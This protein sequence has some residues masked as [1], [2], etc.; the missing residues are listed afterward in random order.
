MIYNEK[1]IEKLISV[2]NELLEIATRYETDVTWSHYD[3]KDEFI[4][5]LDRHL[6]KLQSQD[7]SEIGELKSLFAPTGSLQEI[8]LSSGWA[9]NYLKIASDFDRIASRIM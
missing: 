2:L 7:L 6:S 5:D 9:E 3:T 4:A 1:H 8:S